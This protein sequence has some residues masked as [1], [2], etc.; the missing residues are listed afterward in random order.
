M[1][2]TTDIDALIA[3]LFNA[4]KHGDEEHRTWLKEAIGN[5]FAG[6]PVPPPRGKGNTEKMQA[7]I[8]RLREDIMDA[9]E[10]L[11]V[12][13]MYYNGLHRAWL[14]QTNADVKTFKTAEECKAWCDETNRRLGTEGLEQTGNHISAQ[15]E[16][17]Q[18]VMETAH[19][20]CSNKL[21]VLLVKA[22]CEALAAV[23]APPE[24][25]GK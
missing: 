14:N 4:I 18:D 16:R 17:Q 7:D 21:D 6:L 19:I 20:V 8:K 3:T 5:H 25:E 15:L 1:T 12:R 11:G 13:P 2:D 24:G 22:L 9:V 23:D 10:G